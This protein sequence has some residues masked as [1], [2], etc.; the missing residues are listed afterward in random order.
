MMTL[1][2]ACLL[3][4]GTQPADRQASEPTRHL[5]AA[6]HRLP[7]KGYLFGHQDDLAYGVNWRYASGRSDVLDVT[8]DYPGLFGWDLSGCESGHLTDID[9]VPFDSIRSY[10][11]F[12]YAH[13]GVNTFSWHCPNPLGGTAW[14]ATPGT[15]ASILP[16]GSRHALY[17]SW[18]SRLGAFIR[19]FDDIP[20]LLRPFHELTGGWFWWGAP[21]C[22]TAEFT[23]LWEF[24]RHY[25]NDT[26][27][28]HNILW[29]YNPGDNFSS[30]ADFMARY[31]G[32]SAVDVVS[33]DAY[34]YDSSFGSS[35]SH[36]LSVLDS[37]AR[38]TG[39]V[40]ALA[41]T[42]YVRVPDP[43]W[44]TGVVAP[45]LAHHPIAYMLVW[46]NQGW[47]AW[48]KPPAMEYYAPYKGQASAKDFVRFYRMGNTL[49][50]RDAAREKLYQ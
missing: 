23:T 38:L 9:G 28:L 44:W 33:F 6:L 27:G 40:E 35:L 25:L 2:L 48:S 7:A 16:G 10:V 20:I 45:A 8:G 37:A 50:L 15:V 46:R 4:G 11:R 14:A 42:G 32:D 26:L 41:E 47:N 39:K 5:L 36:R 18:L 3:A 17:V 22:S 13:G 21:H 30:L 31:P 34:Q 1:L 24:T 43:E 19:G 29:V 12:V 49:F